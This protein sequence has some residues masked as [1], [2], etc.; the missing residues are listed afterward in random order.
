M[1]KPK[2]ERKIYLQDTPREEA[3]QELLRQFQS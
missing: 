1:K 3:L 2:Y